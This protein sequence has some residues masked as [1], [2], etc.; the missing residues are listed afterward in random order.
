MKPIFLLLILMSA[1]M[2]SCAGESASETLANAEEELVQG[3]IASARKTADGLVSS[4]RSANLTAVELARLSIVYMSMAEVEA[5]NTALVATAA[6][7]YR[8]ACRENADSA[9]SYYNALP[10]KDAG[11][12]ARLFHIVVATDSAGTMPEEEPVAIDTVAID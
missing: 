2:A 8:R 10:P 12:A 5:D 6:D 11:L 9:A 1:A 3:D 7:L 4:D